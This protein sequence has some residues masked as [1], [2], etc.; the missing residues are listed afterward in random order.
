MPS[1]SCASGIGTPHD[2]NGAGEEDA[3]GTL[4]P[5]GLQGHVPHSREMPLPPVR[6]GRHLLRPRWIRLPRGEGD[7]FQGGVEVGGTQVL[8][9]RHGDDHLPH[10]MP[11]TGAGFA[12][13][14]CTSRPP[15]ELTALTAGLA[16]GP[17]TTGAS[18]RLAVLLGLL[19]TRLGLE[20]A[21]GVVPNV[22]QPRV[23]RVLQTGRS[24][25]GTNGEWGSKD[26]TLQ[27]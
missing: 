9:G 1:S 21:P 20:S 22:R 8:A 26:G 2:H 6:P 18:G 25:Q 11:R 15:R 12:L 4:H 14:P 24:V 16:R 17:S 10:G 13:A 23:E 7:P 27:Q 19:H 3:E 5:P